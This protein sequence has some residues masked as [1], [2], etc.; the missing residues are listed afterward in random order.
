MTTEQ[1]WE[2]F[3]YNLRVQRRSQATL[4]F[5][6][7]TR[8]KLAGYLTLEGYPQEVPGLT[9]QHLRSFV[10]WL[11]AQGLNP[12]GQHAHV[13]AVKALFN[14]SCR[15]ELITV[16]PA[17]RLALPPLPR[18][19]LPTV[20]SSE[21]QRLLTTAKTWDQPLRDAAIIM[22]LFDTG[23]RVSELVK[24]TRQDLLAA[25]GL[26]RV[27]GGK[28][29]KDRTVPI[30]TRTLTALGAYQRRERR[31]RWPHVEE[32]LLSHRG[33]PLT[34]SGVGIRLARLSVASEMPRE[35]TAP[36]AFR[37][38]FAVEFLRN[39]GDVFTLQQI[40]GHA[41]LD[42]TRRYVSFLDEDL[43]SAHLRFSP[44]DRL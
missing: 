40:M 20:T 44:G 27:R 35:L 32:L 7:V 15:E 33:E 31:P 11:E 19:R 10:M 36:H 42:M 3:F 13:R 24:L 6:Q 2:Q 30:G 23:L 9:I 8:Q 18:L 34:R 43:K 14:W 17:T 28:G 21:T 41:S 12:G 25:Q 26:L 5:Y 39:G 16:N 29:E 4:S 22:M 1:L 37:R 38:G